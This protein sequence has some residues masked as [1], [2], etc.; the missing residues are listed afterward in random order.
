MG[1]DRFERLTEEQ[2]VS[3]RLVHAHLTSKEIARRLGISGRAVDQRLDRARAVLG[4]PDRI[5]AAKALA[6]HEAA[7]DR[8][9]R[10]SQGLAEPAAAAASIPSTPDE[11]RASHH[12]VREERLAF[13]PE[14]PDR[15]RWLRTLNPFDG[16]RPDDLTPTA[17][18]TL[19][20]RLGALIPIQLGA[21]FLGLYLLL[22]LLWAIGL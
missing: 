13:T 8:L 3:L 21:L 14:F 1:S 12:R 7:S 4:E 20:L 11:D 2:R 9:T 10:D 19:I 6:A 22:K 5:A 16:G 15:W 17:R 18:L